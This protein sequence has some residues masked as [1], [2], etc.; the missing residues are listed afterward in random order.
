M[1]GELIASIETDTRSVQEK[2]SA[3]APQFQALDSYMQDNTVKVVINAEGGKEVY[4][5]YKFLNPFNIS[6]N[7]SLQNLSSYYTDIGLVWIILYVFLFIGLIY[8]LISGKRPLVGISIVTLFGWTLWWFLGGGILWYAIGI[9]VW[10]ILAFLFYLYYVLDTD[11]EGATSTLS[12][13]FVFAFVVFGSIQMVLNLVRISSQGGGGAFI[14]YKTNYG[15]QQVLT[16]SLQAANTP[17]GG[18]SS[19]DVFDLQFPHYRDLLT[20]AN[21]RGEDEGVYIAGTYAR[22]FIENQK[23]VK[24]D[25]FMGRLFEM[26]SDND[27]CN[28]Y[29][30]LQDQ[31]IKYIVIDPN[32]GT[33]VQGAGNQSLFDRFFAR[34]NTLTNTID[35]HGGMTMLASMFQDGYVRYIS[36][37]NLGAKYAYTMPDSVFGGLQG[38]ELTLFRARMSVA[39]YFGNGMV[40]P[41]VE[42][43]MQRVKDGT[44]VTDIADMMG[45]QVDDTKLMNI[46]LKGQPTVQDIATLTQ[47]ERRALQQFIAIRQQA[48][49]GDDALR[50][51]LTNLVTSNLGGG[52]QLIVL[53]LVE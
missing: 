32:I 30:R 46:V 50:Q 39:R 45:L 15:I 22:Y 24:D 38:D 23:Y 17:E 25:G 2:A 43:A 26:S 31:H 40:T 20:I 16:D 5:P 11:E 12:Y 27:T 28:T 1:L 42:I 19:E 9:I 13:L 52:N 33:V 29:L 8:G 53:E 18:F 51:N 47:D 4:F 7:R 48:T 49:G 36:S 34:V 41:I 37:N 6:F 21:Q 10:T 3:Y 14:W 44:F 35:E